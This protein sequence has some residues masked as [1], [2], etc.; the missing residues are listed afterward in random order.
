MSILNSS[1]FIIVA[2][3]AVWLFSFVYDFFKLKTAITE[4]EKMIVADERIP[5]SAWIGGLIIFLFMFVL[6]PFSLTTAG[7]Q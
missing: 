6:I 5:V 2:W 7:L 4:E 3:A 1:I